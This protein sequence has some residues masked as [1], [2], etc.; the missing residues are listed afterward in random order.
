MP[1]PD[2]KPPP[3]RFSA[4]TALASS[5]SRHVE[6]GSTPLRLPPRPFAGPRGFGPRA[7]LWPCF[8]PLALMGFALQGLPLSAAPIRLVT[9]W[10]PSRRFLCSK[11]PCSRNVT[12]PEPVPRGLRSAKSP[13]P[14]RGVLHPIRGRYPP[15]L[16]RGLRRIPGVSTVSTPDGPQPACT[17]PGVASWNAAAFRMRSLPREEPFPLRR[18]QQ[19]RRLASRSLRKAPDSPASREVAR[20]TLRSSSP[21]TE[22]LRGAGTPFAASSDDGTSSLEVSAGPDA[23]ASSSSLQG[24]PLFSR[25]TGLSTGDPLSAFLPFQPKPVRAAPPGACAREESVPMA[26]GHWADTLLGFT[27]SAASASGPGA[28][29]PLQAGAAHPLVTLLGVPP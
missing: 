7:A 3:L 12:G 10:F 8:M 9:R 26:R 4:P 20:P 29:S 19:S 1:A 21:S 23:R 6:A 5:S 17:P 14:R 24:L 2:W 25:S 16:G 18:F 11:P 28:G 13:C 27:T 15:G 22:A